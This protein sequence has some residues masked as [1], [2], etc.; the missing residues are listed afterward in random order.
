[1]VPV[2]FFSFGICISLAIILGI[3]L[4]MPAWKVSNF[5]KQDCDLKGIEERKI[6]CE[7]GE[8]CR[9]SF[10]CLSVKV[11]FKDLF[12]ENMRQEMAAADEYTLVLHRMNLGVIDTCRYIMKLAMSLNYRVR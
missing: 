6:Y 8:Q 5:V 10:P 3:K 11:E 12:A 4:L 7:C 9:S 2:Y 1:M